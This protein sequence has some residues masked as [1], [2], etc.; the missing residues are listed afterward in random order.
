MCSEVIFYVPIK[1]ASIHTE[2]SVVLTMNRQNVPLRTGLPTTAMNPVPTP[3]ASPTVPK[4][5]VTFDNQSEYMS[6]GFDVSESVVCIPGEA[7]A[8]GNMAPSPGNMTPSVVE[9]MQDGDDFSTLSSSIGKKAVAIIGEKGSDRIS[10]AEDGGRMETSGE[11]K[12]E[13]SSVVDGG[14]EKSESVDQNRSGNSDGSNG[15]SYSHSDVDSQAYEARSNEEEEEE[16][17]DAFIERLSNMVDIADLLDNDALNVEARESVEDVLNVEARA[18]VK[19]PSGMNFRRSGRTIRN[20]KR[21]IEEMGGISVDDGKT[22][23]KDCL[24]QVY[25][26]ALVGAGIGGGFGHTSELD[27]KKYNEALKSNDLDELAKWV[28]GIEEEHARFLFDDVWIVVSK[29]DYADVIPIT[30]T[31]ALKQKASGVVRARCNVRGF[32]Q[33]PHIH[34][35]PD[36]KSSPVTTQAAVF[37]VFVLLTMKVDYV[38][39][40][41]NVKGAFLKG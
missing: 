12:E 11:Q 26:F 4:G 5:P 35:D 19:D 27:I 41:L 14:D 9:I 22:T 10:N 37:I 3:V 29:G 7:P 20:P 13:G 34:Y 38:A 39:R 1:A 17:D 21:L 30:M 16:D 25:E 15:I 40:V 2:D 33:I 28:Q 31:W 24:M 18:R 6:Q 8:Q 36:S 23:W 32:E